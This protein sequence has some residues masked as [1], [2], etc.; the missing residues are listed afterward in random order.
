VHHTLL[1]MFHVTSARSAAL[2]PLST[3][4][5][6]GQYGWRIHPAY[7]IVQRYKTFSRRIYA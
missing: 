3:G 6:G 2:P 7:R 5:H 1:M 4:H